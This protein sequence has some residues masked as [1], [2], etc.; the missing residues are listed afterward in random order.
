MKHDLAILCLIGCY[1]L[2]VYGI[3]SVA[4]DGFRVPRARYYA[5]RTRSVIR[6]LMRM[7]N[8]PVRKENA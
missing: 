7:E 2:S 3:L 6:T 8:S 1:A 5:R 4:G